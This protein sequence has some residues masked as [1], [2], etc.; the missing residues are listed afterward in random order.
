MSVGQDVEEE[1][2]AYGLREHVDRFLVLDA[3][4]PG[5]WLAIEHHLRV[6]RLDLRTVRHHVV[7]CLDGRRRSGS[8]SRARRFGRSVP[9]G[10]F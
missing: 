6:P 9:R 8:S 3:G 4:L 5:K 10:V 1:E 2:I 7:L